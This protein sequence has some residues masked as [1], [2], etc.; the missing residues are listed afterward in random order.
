MEYNLRTKKTPSKK[1][2]EVR[3]IEDA[4][5]NLGFATVEDCCSEWLEA[6]KK[7]YKLKVKEKRIGLKEGERFRLARAQGTKLMCERWLKSD[8]CYALCG[9][10]GELLIEKLNERV[11]EWSK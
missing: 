2:G 7:E 6:A 11:K 1:G 4:W 8:F 5:R 3:A 9:M 10:E